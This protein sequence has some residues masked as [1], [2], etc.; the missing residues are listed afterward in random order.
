[1]LNAVLYDV[2]R[3]NAI[4][5]G[6]ALPFILMIGVGVSLLVRSDDRRYRWGG[7]ALV[8]FGFLGAATSAGV[9]VMQRRRLS[10]RLRNGEFDRVEGMI[11]DFSPGST[12]G[13]TPE[14]FKVAGHVY[15]FRSK[16]HMAGYHEV[17]G[18][19]GPLRDGVK[20]RIADINGIVA[21][22]ELIQ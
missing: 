1:L 14:A 9:D 13:H 18:E 10:T 16:L 3:T 8:A 6:D 7:I 19:D 4:D 12:D 21:R 20:M 11:S 2:T 15:T 5:W 22:L 17:Q